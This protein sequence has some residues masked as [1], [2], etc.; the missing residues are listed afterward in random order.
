MNN[1]ITTKITDITNF[2]IGFV[3]W[4]GDKRSG[5]EYGFIEIPNFKDVYFNTKS[6]GDHSWSPK[7]GD[8]VVCKIKTNGDKDRAIKVNCLDNINDFILLWELYSFSFKTDCRVIINCVE[9][10]EK[11]GALYES[12][13]QSSKDLIP[14][15]SSLRTLLDSLSELLS[16]NWHRCHDLL[17][18]LQ[19]ILGPHFRKMIVNIAENI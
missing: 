14:L 16:P 4:F 13:S 1:T 6:V 2:H 15:V 7:E 5:K 12:A 3:K 18:T 10:I 9:I 17:N 8:I 11:L 19:A